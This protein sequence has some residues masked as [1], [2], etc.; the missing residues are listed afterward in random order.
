MV[1]ILLLGSSG[2]NANRVTINAPA[3]YLNLA[4]GF[5]F[6]IDPNNMSS[7]GYPTT[8]PT[9]GTYGSNPSFPPANYFG[10]FVWKW[11]GTGAMQWTGAPPIVVT[12]G[13]L[14]IFELNSASGDLAA[15]NVSVVT[16]NLAVGATS[17]RIVFSVGWNIQAIANNG[18]GLIRITT[19]TGFASTATTGLVVTITGANANTN[20]N[21]TWTITAVDNQNFDLQSSTFANTQGVAGTATYAGSG[22]TSFKMLNGFGTS[23]SGMSDLVIC[24]STDEASIT[25]GLIT[26]L[27]LVNQLK[28]LMNS[29]SRGSP[30]WLRFMDLSAVQ[31]SFEG[32]FAQRV[33]STYL[34][35]NATGVRPGYW[36]P[37]ASGAITRAASDVYTCS[38]PS[39]SVWNGSTYIDNA[40]VQGVPSATNSAGTPTLNV[41]GHGAKPIFNIV[42]GMPPFVLKLTGGAPSPG[43][44][45]LQFTFTANSWTSP[46]LN[47]GAPY[48]FNY[49]TVAG[50]GT[51]ATLNAN[52]QLALAADAT[53]AAA[54]IF[55]VNPQNGIG[56]FVLP[57]TAQ[58]QRLAIT[59][60]SGPA[61]V[62]VQNMQISS[63]TAANTGTF[64]YNY[65]LDGWLYRNGGMNTTIPFEAIVDFCNQVGAHCWLPLGFTKGAWVT[66]VAQ[67]FGDSVT[68]L[69]SGLRFGNEPWNEIWNSSAS[70]F[71]Q[72]QSLGCALGWG[73]SGLEG[74]YSYAGLRAIQ[75]AALAKA[76]WIGKGRSAS[77]Y[78]VLQPSA[79]FD[80]T[81]SGNFDSFQLK[82]TSLTTS[83]NTY[84]T[85]GGLNGGSAPS[86]TAAGSRPVDITTATGC[87][88]Y[89]G[90]PWWGGSAAGVGSIT[91]VITQ[92]IPWLQASLDFTNGLTTTAYTSLANQFNGTTTRAAGSSSGL[93]LAQQYAASIFPAQEALCAQYDSYRS[94]AGLQPLGIIDYEGGPQW[95]MGADYIS[96]VNSV[97][98]TDIT[99]LANRMTALS[100]NV[101][102]YTVSGTDNKTECATQVITMTQAWK[103]DASYKNMIK[104]SYYQALVSVSGSHRETRP[105]QY[106]YAAQ[107]WGVFPVSYLAGNQYMNYDAISEFNA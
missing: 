102:A 61:I 76:A 67:F 6:N 39:V 96:G 32:D 71:A 30:G 2:L 65:L 92:N 64:V 1:G 43:V 38:D 68:G 55:F 18:S 74:T 21:G 77:D 44:D 88:P 31:A 37:S 40:I 5:G 106:G 16:Q 29:A 36:T 10:S 52:L 14:N 46:Q 81:S 41:G 97:N 69:R 99:A 22:L 59:Y 4:K 57:R 56:P 91:G 93:L 19:K 48:V 51:L 9:G 87:A 89:W 3:G 107:S 34:C 105:A 103:Y 101:S 49:T 28:Y 54:K 100:W 98:S 26:D 47:G 66:A 35:Y 85:Y 82:G 11:T 23:F 53:L 83:N 79:T 60:T 73:V 72:I 42:D 17:P 33:P 27:V 20:A 62:L 70:P 25:A 86:Y 94:G 84:A 8:T 78:Y 95:G 75:Y 45:V 50:D 13:G 90:S 15:G 63:I 12:S 80:V 24:R 104:A 58:Q 7:D